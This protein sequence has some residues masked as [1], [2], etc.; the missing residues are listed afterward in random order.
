[1]TGYA[2]NAAVGNGLVGPGTEV[3]SK[4]FAVDALADK[5]RGML[6]GA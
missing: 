5:V 4:P 6:R 3:I 2:H 1:M